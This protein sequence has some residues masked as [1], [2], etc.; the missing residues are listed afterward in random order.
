MP[1]KKNQATVNAPFVTFRP[2]EIPEFEKYRFF[3]ISRKIGG[4][5]SGFM[6]F[7]GVLLFLVSF[8]YILTFAEIPL[9]NP[10]FLD[11]MVFFGIIQLLCGLLLLTTE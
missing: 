4:Y 8:T 11:A 10:L 7:I 5:F 2:E 1:K 9:H 3:E 6:I